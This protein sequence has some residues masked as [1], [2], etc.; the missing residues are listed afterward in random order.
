MLFSTGYFPGLP[1]LHRLMHS[2]H[3]SK[4]KITG[5]ALRVRCRRLCEKKPSGRYNVDA[6]IAE[7]YQEGGESRE[8]LEMALLECIAK[9]GLERSSYKRIKAISL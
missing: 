8:C 2:H 4:V 7:Q 3:L 1:G 9:H 5:D 6:K